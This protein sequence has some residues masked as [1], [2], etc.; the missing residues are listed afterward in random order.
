[1]RFKRAGDCNA[2]NRI[3]KRVEYLNRII[4]RKNGLIKVI[5]DLSTLKNIKDSFVQIIV[6]KTSMKSWV[7]E[8]G[9]LLISS[10]N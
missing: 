3:I 1:M 8:E 2:K 9:I 7:D 6:S 5:T 10:Y 4:Y